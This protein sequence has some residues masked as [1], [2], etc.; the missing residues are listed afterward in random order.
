MEV[1][2]IEIDSG[3]IVAIYSMKTLLAGQNYTPSDEQYFDEAWGYAVED[4]VVE[5]D[6]R[7]KYRIIY[8]K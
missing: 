3:Q 2:I 4:G 5:P 1:S 6:N 8:S 7:D